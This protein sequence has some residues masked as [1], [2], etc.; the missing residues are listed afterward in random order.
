MEGTL[1]LPPN[2]RER[3]ETLFE[4]YA[5]GLGMSGSVEFLPQLSRRRDPIPGHISG[6]TPIE[7]YLIFAI[8]VLNSETSEAYGSTQTGVAFTADTQ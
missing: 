7:R 6:S 2:R 3:F 8:L 1:Y 5:K 4:G